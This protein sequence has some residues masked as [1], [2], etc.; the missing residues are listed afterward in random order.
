MEMEKEKKKKKKG[1]RMAASAATAMEARK[2]TRAPQSPLGQLGTI[3]TG[4][5]R[6]SVL[7]GLRTPA[8]QRWIAGARSDRFQADNNQSVSDMRKIITRTT[9]IIT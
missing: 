6:P 5:W 4:D 8:S 7:I 2:V 1:K 3:G 9:T